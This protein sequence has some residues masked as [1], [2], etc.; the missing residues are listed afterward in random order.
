MKLK[1]DGSKLVAD[2]EHTM[3]KHMI[4]C[5]EDDFLTTCKVPASVLL[6]AAQCT[7]RVLIS[8]VCRITSLNVGHLCVNNKNWCLVKRFF[9]LCVHADLRSLAARWV[10]A[11]H[12]MK[13]GCC[14]STCS[15]ISFSSDCRCQ[16]S[17]FGLSGW[18][19]KQ[20]QNLTFRESHQSSACLANHDYSCLCLEPQKLWTIGLWMLLC[21]RK[22]LHNTLPRTRT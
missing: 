5:W 16:L 3:S 4:V 13:R 10:S 15:A 18:L 21:S 17:F 19:A 14:L 8:W 20:S 9:C 6:K 7:R 1:I 22:W 11:I 12:F 2:A